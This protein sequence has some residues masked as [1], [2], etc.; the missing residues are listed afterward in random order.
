MLKKKGGIQQK[1]VIAML[2]AGLLSAVLVII[3]TYLDAS[4]AFYKALENISHQHIFIRDFPEETHYPIYS[5]IFKLLILGPTG[6][7]ILFLF[8]YL[9]A[10]WISVPIKELSSDVDLMIGKGRIDQNFKINTGDEIEK[11]TKGFNHMAKDIEDKLH[12]I[13]LERDKL[14]T[15]MNSIGDGL[16][17]LDESYRIQ[18]MNETF[19]ELYGPESVGKYCHDVFGIVDMPCKGCSINNVNNAKPHTIEVITERGLTY[20][21]THSCIKNLD[22]SIS[23]VEIFKDITSRKRLEQQLLTSERLSALSQFSSTFAHDLR[24]PIVAIKKTLEML[25]DS[26]VFY[27]KESTKEI[28]VDLIA[29]CDL[30]LG[31]VNDVLDIHQVSYRDLPLLYS[32]FSITQALEEVIRLLRIEAEEREINVLLESNQDVFIEGDKRRIQRVFINLLSNA[33]RYS[34]SSGNI[35]MSFTIASES[36]TLLFRIGDE[37]PGISP[38]ELSQIFDIFYKK[39]RDGIKGGTGLGLY[40]CKVVVEA[41]GGKIWA[42]DEGD[43]GAVFYLSIPLSIPIAKEGGRWQ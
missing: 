20:L 27:Q 2:V 39:E 7:G 34:P 41:H 6:I 28:Y 13:K 37:G 8:S 3:L 30:L 14:N 29:N 10:K 19:L 42:G 25:K 11:L 38:E 12:E 1:I 5:L 43:D 33:I 18:Y 24:N 32:S 21:I 35:K 15:V 9:A 36:S 26:S 40:F 4:N 23:I 22:E 17:I 16:V 31:L